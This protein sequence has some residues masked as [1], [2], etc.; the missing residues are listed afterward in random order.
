MS[1]LFDE[2]GQPS[3]KWSKEMNKRVAKDAYALLLPVMRWIAE[4]PEGTLT[5]VR[6]VS[7]LIADYMGSLATHLFADAVLADRGAQVKGLV[8][9]DWRKY[10]L[11]DTD[12]EYPW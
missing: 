12:E 8:G 7:D 3:E 11:K 6:V 1:A 2:F 10:L 4:Q 9:Y 5:D